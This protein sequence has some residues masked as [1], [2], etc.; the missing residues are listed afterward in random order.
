MK[1]VQVIAGTSAIALTV[2]VLAVLGVTFANA[3]T[4]PTPTQTAVVA[5]DPAPVVTD[6][7]TPVPTATQ[8]P[9][10]APAPDPAPANNWAP[11]Q[12]PAGTPIP[13][14]LDTDPNSGSYNQMI[15][16]NPDQF[17]ASKGGTTAADGTQV[18]S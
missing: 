13:K 17:C 4:A 15:I 18:C 1:T 3:G 9:V 2:G 16:E 8:A 10:V 6:T 12:A 11:G 14:Y 7:P 5:V